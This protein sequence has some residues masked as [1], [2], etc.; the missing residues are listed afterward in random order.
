MFK[1]ILSATGLFLVLAIM[2][3][4][5]CSSDKTTSS[6]DTNTYLHIAF[7][8]QSYFDRVTSLTATVTA[9]DIDSPITAIDTMVQSEEYSNITISIPAGSG[10][11]IDVAGLDSAGQQL[12][13]TQRTVTI[14]S[15]A[16]NDISMTLMPAGYASPTKVKLFRNILPFYNPT[17]PESVLIDLGFT[18]GAGTNQY[19]VFNSSQMGSIV[20]TPGT[21]LVILQAMQET[22]FYKD[23]LASRDYMETFVR[24]GGTMFILYTAINSGAYSDSLVNMVFPGEVDYKYRLTNDNHPVVEDHPIMAG[25]D[26]VLHGHSASH[27]Y[28]DDLVP[29]TLV[30][31]VDTL[32]G[33]TLLIYGF[34]KGTVILSGQPLEFYRYYRDTYPALGSLL[35]RTMRFALGFDP[36]PEPLPRAGNR[37]RVESSTTIR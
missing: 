15:G 22:T 20:Q 35:S 2:I 1:A 36:T 16:R 25:V 29:G 37:Q 6:A 19:Q 14:A 18:Q 33:P 8:V 3:L 4:G 13:R 11:N 31:T 24:E 7:P 28:F 23:Y 27:G 21:D 26:Y 30:L 34:G 10:R 5:G 9:D 32:S 12:Y 17:Q